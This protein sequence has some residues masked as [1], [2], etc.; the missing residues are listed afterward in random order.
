MFLDE[1][2]GDLAIQSFVQ[3]VRKRVTVL[4]IDEQHGRVQHWPHKA[5]FF[6]FLKFLRPHL[7]IGLH[8]QSNLPMAVIEDAKHIAAYNRFESHTNST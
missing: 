3:V 2:M 4:S 1:N 6:K 5:I 7:Q 8:V